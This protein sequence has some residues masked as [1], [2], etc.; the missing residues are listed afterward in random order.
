LL[1]CNTNKYFHQ[2]LVYNDCKWWEWDNNF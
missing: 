2:F 1:D